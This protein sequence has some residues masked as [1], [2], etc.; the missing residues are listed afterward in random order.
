MN[1]NA[2]RVS[3]DLSVMEN[4]SVLTM[5]LVTRR[6][7]HVTVWQDGLESIA[8]IPAP[9]GTTARTVSQSAGVRMGLLV[10]Q[11]TATVRV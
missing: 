10:T 6:M 2:V 1:W 3:L 8:T 4:V 7:V 9:L 11:L 5:Q